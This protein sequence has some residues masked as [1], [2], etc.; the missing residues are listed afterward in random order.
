M[1]VMEREADMLACSVCV[2]EDWLF[3]KPRPPQAER[4]ELGRVASRLRPLSCPRK[5]SLVQGRQAGRAAPVAVARHGRL[6]PLPAMLAQPSRQD[7]FQR[8]VYSPEFYRQA[9][10]AVRKNL[11]GEALRSGPTGDARWPRLAQGPA[12]LRLHAD[13]LADEVGRLARPAACAA[14]SA[15]GWCYRRAR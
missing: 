13:P 6:E 5:I 8:R 2:S 12:R 15:S 9:R 11:H 3:R 14:P 4:W 10:A 7:G 1:T